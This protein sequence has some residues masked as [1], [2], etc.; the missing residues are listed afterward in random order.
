MGAE[1]DLRCSV[2][3]HELGERP[4]GS[5]GGDHRY[6]L[7]ELPLPWPKKIDS[8]PL[9]DEVVRPSAATT[10]RTTTVLGI[11]STDDEHLG[12]HRVICYERTTP[13]RG[14]GRVE[15]LVPTEALAQTV[16]AL[17]S[18]GAT[19]LDH[20]T[21][22][23]VPPST[24][25]LLLCTHGSRDRCCGQ[26]GTLLHLELDGALPSNVRMWRTSHT[27]GHRFAPTGI[28]FPTGTAWAYLTAELTQAI[29]ER[30]IDT[31]ELGAH[32]RG[33]VGISG[34]PAQI[35]EGYSFLERGWSWLDNGR[36]VS[37][38]SGIKGEHTATVVASDHEATVTL[39]E[40]APVPVPICGE[41]VEQS[42]KFTTQLLVT[43]RTST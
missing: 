32:Y 8:H 37:V 1:A 24:E 20:N 31:T 6:L 27:G 14:F 28:H 10:T 16:T 21:I 11:R 43:D 18:G 34:R 26:L 5:A 19:A 25:D 15:T 29:V 2:I 33:N 30:S 17:M 13:F 12:A 7:I 3:S 23:D 9:L 41:G 36:S 40:E 4:A 38:V 39:V 42:V 35:A 22:V